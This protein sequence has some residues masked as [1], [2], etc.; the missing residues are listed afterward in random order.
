MTKS[1]LKRL[2]SLSVFLLFGACSYSAPVEMSASY[3]V[4]SSYE[5]KVPGN[6]AIWIDSSEFVDNNVTA[7]TQI[8]SA[9]SFPIDA[10]AVFEKS[11]VN[12]FANITENIERV[13]NPIPGDALKAQGF[14]GQIV[15]EG[16]DMDVD[17]IFLPGFWSA[18]TEAEVEFE[19]SL[20][21]TVGSTKVVGTTVSADGEYNSDAGSACDGGAAAIGE[22]A[23]E[24][25]QKI[26]N[27]LGE[28][29]ASST[30]LRD[31]L[32]NQ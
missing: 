29:F 15:I 2:S 32:K 5:E 23:G 8:C 3:N 26:L 25:M 27:R 11:A 31:A 10:R 1:S 13:N 19:A 21:A 16:Q 14:D 20:T 28:A 6:W 17:L 12:T 24:G 7:K 30:R 4:K 18:K 9:H 22:A